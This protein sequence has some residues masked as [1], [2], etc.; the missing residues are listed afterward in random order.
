VDSLL[1][2]LIMHFP[3][4]G[5]VG[6]RTPPGPEGDKVWFVMIALVCHNTAR[7]E[8][9]DIVHEN[10]FGILWS[11]DDVSRFML[12]HLLS[13][14]LD[15]SEPADVPHCPCWHDL[16]EQKHRSLTATTFKRRAGKWWS[17]TKQAHGRM[18][19]CL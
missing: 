12:E 6:L 11:D 15:S 17:S 4:L 13:A 16:P 18:F 5:S 2:S 7:Q 8:R 14:G 10:T 3:D 19:G 9:H 1:A